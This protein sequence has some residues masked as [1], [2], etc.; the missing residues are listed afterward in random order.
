MEDLTSTDC[1][2]RATHMRSHFIGIAAVLL[3]LG[4]LFNVAR[5]QD[6]L[7]RPEPSQFIF[8][9]RT[10]ADSAPPP[11]WP[12]APAAPKGAPNVLLILTDD[13]GFGSSS[14]FGGPI[15]TPT[16]DAL[17]KS[18]L[19][20][21]QFHTTAMC[22]P[23]R[24]ALLTGRNH[25]EVGS[26]HVTESA[27][28][29]DGYTSIMPRSAATIAEI[30]KDNGYSTAAIGK[31]HNTPDWETSQ[32]GPFDHWPTDMGFQY[33]YGFQGGGTNQ[34][35]PHLYQG[36]VP[37]QPALDDPTYILERDLADRAIAWIREQKSV[38]PTKPFFLY[39]ATAAAHAPHQAPKDWIAK[40]KGEFDQGWDKVRVETLARQKALGI[41]PA[42]TK[43]TARPKEIPAWDSLSPDQKAVYARLMEAYA[44]T[45]AHSDHQIG[46]V[47]DAIRDLRQLDNTLVIFIEGDNGSS[48]EGGPDGRLNE[49]T[50][51]N[52][53]PQNFDQ[54]RQHIADIGG[55]LTYNHYPVG[56]AHAMDAP[57][58][59]F[60]QVASHFGGTRNG[61][62]ISWPARIKKKGEI[63]TQFH[64]VVDVVPTILDAIGLPAPAIVNGVAQKP[65]AGLSMAYSFDNPKAPSPRHM[66]YFELFG[67][68]AI[69]HDGWV[70][71]AG[72]VEMPWSISL[73]PKSIDAIRWELYHVADDFSEATDLAAQH[74]EKLRELQD[75][76]WAEAARNHVLPI[77]LGKIPPGPPKPNPALGRKHFV[78]FPGSPSIPGGSAPN[79]VGSSFAIKAEVRVREANA[80][81]VLFAE[82]GR[83]G[84]QVLYVHGGKLVYHYNLLGVA[85]YTVTSS[86]PIAPGRHVLGVD[87][88]Y[89][90]GGF[91]KG[92]V[93]TLLIDGA[94]A[95]VGRVERTAPFVIEYGEGVDVGRDTGTPVSEDYQV[96]FDFA[97]QLDKVTVTLQ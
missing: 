25:H 1:F 50:F 10:P 18:G 23:T 70:A 44:G 35:A 34:F 48:A 29:Y 75:L 2:T 77:I 65:M 82:G 27:N 37:V 78:Y 62:V 89:D 21:T 91:G 57:F 16:L 9:G 30:L 54:L 31:W 55:P 14:T 26:G 7:P 95:S 4:T 6:V 24:A 93:A 92:A 76:F 97:G 67:N 13:V 52:G 86:T 90:G 58:Q 80:S 53:M 66:Q 79:L 8:V 73:V 51:M 22:S 36:T 72:P 71:A 47:I 19:R 96:P 40:F 42:N 46:R 49:A 3:G 68:R 61:M 63:R 69:Y 20:Y 43:L 38:R 87:F 17:A 84:G 45:L 88:K 15:P 81:G 32:A 74:P 41:V 11:V 39:Y 33:F 59:W 64:H 83:F 94:S 85:R 5:A 28:A 56:W 60:K 12:K